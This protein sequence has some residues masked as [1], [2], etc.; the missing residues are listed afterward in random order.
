MRKTSFSNSSLLRLIIPVFLAAGFFY[1]HLH[2]KQDLL[3]VHFMDVGY[4]DAILVEFPDKTVLL[5]DAGE[6][7]YSGRIIGY[8][9]GQGIKEI[10]AAVLTHPHDNH[11][12]GFAAIMN[13]FPIRRFYFNGDEKNA[14]EGYADLTAGLKTRVPVT[15]VRRNDEIPIGAGSRSGNIR[16]QILHPADLNGSA[17][18]NSIV[19]WLTFGRTSFL[20]T[21]DIQGPQQKQIMELFP[22]I[23]SADAI[24]VPHHGGRI[25]RKF[26]AYLGKKIFIVSTGKNKYNKP[27]ARELEKLQGRIL[28]TDRQGTIVLESDGK[29]VRVVHE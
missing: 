10:D 27:F 28:R 12:G 18:R 24:Q 4:G 3:R 17:N 1:Y 20:F 15:V 22:E 25:S 6:A 29:K 13:R 14:E 11:F 16:I 2:S 21:A 19:S 8:L 7:Q 26:A 5:I 23:R 9:E